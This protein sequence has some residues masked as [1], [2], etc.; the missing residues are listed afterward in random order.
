VVGVLRRAGF[1]VTDG[2]GWEDYDALVVTSSLVAG[3][4]VTTGYPE[5]TMQVAVS[6]HLRPYRTA[7]AVVTAASAAL[8]VPVIGAAIAAATLAEIGRGCWGA[9]PRARRVVREAARASA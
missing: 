9:G 4:L 1:W 8:V 3:R 5:G 2:S 6:T 7:A